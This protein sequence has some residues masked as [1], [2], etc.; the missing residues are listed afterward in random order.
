MTAGDAPAR[1]AAE[2]PAVLVCA[3]R[4]P[5]GGAGVDADAEALAAAGCVAHCVVTTVTD[6]DGVRVRGLAPRAPARWLG[7]ARAVLERHD[8]RVVK[9][10]LLADAAALR[11]AGALAD[12]VARAG[13]RVVVDPVLAASGGERFLAAAD[14]PT[15]AVELFARGAV[16]TPNLLEAAELTGRTAAQLEA[17]DERVAAARALLAAGAAAVVL[18]GGHGRDDPVRDLVLAAGG[19]PTWVEHGRVPGR[20]LHGSGCRHASFLAGRLARGEDLVDASRG[21]GAWLAARIA[22]GR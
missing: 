9:F 10:G 12:A 5:T 16:V 19:T 3:G 20:G 2:G 8:V 7:E 22:A 6:Q 4:D 1:R 15:L 21:A 13:G 17:A 18:K 14:V 11:A